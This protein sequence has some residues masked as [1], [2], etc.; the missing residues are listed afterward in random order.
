MEKLRRKTRIIKTAL[1]YLVVF[2]SILTGN[3]QNTTNQSQDDW[4]F[5]LAPYL[6]FPYMNGEMGVLG[7]EVDVD[8]GPGDIFSN[9][10]FGIMGYL[11]A[12]KSQWG[13]AVDTQYMALGTTLKRLPVNVDA[14]Q[15]VIA[16]LGMRSLSQNVDLVF[17]A[18]WNFVTAKLEFKGSQNRVFEDT[19][20]WVD[21]L[22][23]LA[24]QQPLGG[25]WHFAVQGDIGGFGA[26]SDFAW[27]VFPRIGIDIGKNSRFGFGYR[28]LG[29]D[30]ET[31]SGNELYRYDVITSGPV[32]GA[33]FRF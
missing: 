33:V 8:V 14:D 27:H 31:G 6:V 5:T 10:Q 1:G 15:G 32:I 21:P 16:F 25:R 24:I 20:N 12:R 7:Q 26:G 3:A 22:V 4:Q 11:E 17:G 28:A 13:L 23:G 18:R 29:M 30:Y 19:K 2:S 9:L